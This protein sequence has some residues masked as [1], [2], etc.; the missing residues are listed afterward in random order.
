MALR[1]GEIPIKLTSL[2]IQ[3][4][5]NNLNNPKPSCTKLTR[6]TGLW[7]SPV[8]TTPNLQPD[9]AD[10][11]IQQRRCLRCRGSGHI[12]SV[13]TIYPKTS[14]EKSAKHLNLMDNK[15]ATDSDDSNILIV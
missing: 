8:D 2:K 3:N 9:D 5:H 10:L 7:Y 4:R 15:I 11:L 13:L 6:W 14:G 1:K 12:V